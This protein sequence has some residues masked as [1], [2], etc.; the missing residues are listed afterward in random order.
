[1][2]LLQKHIVN[3]KTLWLLLI[4][5][6]T[7]LIYIPVLNNGFLKTWDDNRYILENEHI[8]DLTFGSAAGF[9]SMYYDGHYHPLT[10]LSLA[11]DYKIGEL[12]PTVYHTTNLLLHLINTMLVFLF[13]HL[14]FSRKK[15]F[16]A[17]VTALLFGLSTMHVESVAWA[18]ERKNLL[19]ALFFFASLI[20][21]VLFLQ[22][23]KR[24]YFIIALFF[25][26]LSILSKVMAISLCVS[27]LAIDYFFDRKLYSRK[28]ILEKV[29][30]F[31]LAIVFAVVAIY[32]QKSSWGEDLSQNY[33][34]FFER[35]LFAANAFVLY[36]LKLIV[37][38]KLSGF[39]PYP[40]E[41]SVAFIFKSIIFLIVSLV[42]AGAVVYFYKRS[43]TIT[44]GI[45]FFIINIFLLLKLFEVPAGDYIMAD[46]YSYIA[47]V[48]LFL[49]ISAG[50]NYLSSKKAIHK[51][52]ALTVLIVY[53]IFISLQTFNRASVWKND[54]T[55]YTD[56]IS[57][58]PGAK[59]AYTNRG[60]V[61]KNEG[62]LNGALSDF[63][64]AIQL[65]KDDYKAYSNRGAVYSDLGNFEKAVID[66]KKAVSLKPGKPQVLA[67][68]GYALLQTGDIRGAVGSF[69]QSLQLQPVNPEVYTNR[70]TAKYNTGDLQGAIKDYDMAVQQNPRYLNAYYNRGLAK[71]NLSDYHGA[72]TDFT[73]ALK[74]NPNHAEAY[75]NMGI[76][77]SRLDEKDKA[78]DSYNKAIQINPNYFE[79]YLNRGI[80]KY[81]T[82]DYKGALED[83]NKTIQLNRQV[84]PAYYF[85]AMIILQSDKQAACN[86]F[87]NAKNLGFSLAE[88]QIKIYCK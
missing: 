75:S 68:Y 6:I 23:E 78:F 42:V 62:K 33:Y 87:I 13:V 45:L 60:A 65:G 31:L 69:N 36:I 72:I 16:V 38:F 53:S 32:A 49:L 17:L 11:I 48:G 41:V 7:F 80:D 88:K 43:K 70:G 61:R 82:A 29:P 12:N 10:L 1:M 71:L 79:A 46:R 66:Y 30:F 5:A 26:L 64:K 28:V 58:F 21:Y 55:F 63:T 4:I 47:S 20:S 40:G 8:K 81:Y 19:Y 73:G 85:R 9:F 84:G 67:S 77:W 50:L 25:F 44:F 15:F 34:T 35:I 56:I 51:K 59:V 54:I 74:I 83:L 24:K 2:T 18:S 3:K 39:Y 22:Q 52:I 57:K 76:A 86:D 37:P 27:L 14:L